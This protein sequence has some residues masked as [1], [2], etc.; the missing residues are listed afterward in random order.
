MRIITRK[1][2]RAFPELDAFTDEQCAAYLANAKLRRA[3]FSLLVICLPILAGVAYFL[4]VFVFVSKILWIRLYQAGFFKMS[5]TNDLVM[6]VLLGIFLI[7]WFGGSAFVSL[8]LRDFLLGKTLYKAIHSR[9]GKT[10]CEKCRYNLIG[11]RPTGDRLKCPECGRRTTMQE[12]G[13]T[14]DDLIPPAT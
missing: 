3:K 1:L 10:C 9:L 8:C 4:S 11:Q 6:L 2:Y 14:I 5:T 12:L 13:I 7:I